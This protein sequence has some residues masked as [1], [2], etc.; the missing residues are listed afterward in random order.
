VH[1]YLQREGIP[2]VTTDLKERIRA[3]GFEID[4]SR[5]QCKRV[6]IGEWGDPVP[7]EQQAARRVARR[8][9]LE[10][11][12]PLAMSFEENPVAAPG[13]PLRTDDD[14]IEFGN[15]VY[16]DMRDNS[17]RMYIDMYHHVKAR[18]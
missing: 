6:H 2:I 3:V 12:K 5:S 18:N 9:F 7:L 17:Y 8:L 13:I 1:A 15:R 11:I 4:E 16:A 10:C 14:K